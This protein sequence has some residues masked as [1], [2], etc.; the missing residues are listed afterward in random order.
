M[1]RDSSPK[2]GNSTSRDV[3]VVEGAS[4]SKKTRHVASLQVCAVNIIGS[5]F[6]NGGPYE[7]PDIERTLV[8]D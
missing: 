7:E 4:D 6:P 3:D 8:N 5:S 2:R 1:H